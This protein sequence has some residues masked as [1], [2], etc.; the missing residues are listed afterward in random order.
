[1][2]NGILSDSRRR[3]TSQQRLEDRLRINSTVYQCR[4]D[5]KRCQDDEDDSDDDSEKEEAVT[6]K[7]R[8]RQKHCHCPLGKDYTF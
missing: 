4:F 2:G 7:M 1:M 6:N 8:V 3:P 5:Y